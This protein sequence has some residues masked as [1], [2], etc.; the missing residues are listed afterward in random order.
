MPDLHDKF[1][2]MLIDF[3]KSGNNEIKA[4]GCECLARMISHQYI[5]VIRKQMIDMV[6][7]QF[8][9]S[10]SSVTRKIYVQFCKAAVKNFSK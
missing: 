3:I 9:R 5:S 2:Q 7:D 1:T 6:I 10:E 8:A 4:A